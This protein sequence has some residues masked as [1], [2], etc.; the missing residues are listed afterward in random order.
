VLIRAAVIAA[1]LLATACAQY[2][3]PAG[4]RQ[5]LPN[6]IYASDNRAGPWRDE[7]PN[8]YLVARGDFDG[9]GREDV[10]KLLVS[11]DGKRYALL[12]FLA[13]GISVQL[14][15]ANVQVLETQGIETLP[16]GTHRTLCGKGYRSC[17]EG[18]PAVL[19]LHYPAIIFFTEGTASSVFFWSATD[20][21]FRNVFWSD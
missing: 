15:S 8:K 9:D 17:A 1:S 11:T 5:P 19:E 10:A 12:V 6:E 20:K 13:T 2:D 21:A 14:D 7:D 3:L 18:E 4:W 16:T